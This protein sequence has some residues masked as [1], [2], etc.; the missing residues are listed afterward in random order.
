MFYA[1]INDEFKTIK[2]TE[3]CRDVGEANSSSL[4]ALLE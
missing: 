2:W 3:N 1:M 4:K